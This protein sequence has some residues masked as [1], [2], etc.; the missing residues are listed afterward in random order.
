MAGVGTEKIVFG[1]KFAD[2]TI[3]K[4]KKCFTQPRI[5]EL[6]NKYPRLAKNFTKRY[7]SL[8]H[9]CPSPLL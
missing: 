2:T 1:K 7:P 3:K 5:S 6:K 4:S 9:T 8:C